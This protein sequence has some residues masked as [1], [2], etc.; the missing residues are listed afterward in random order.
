MEMLETVATF[1]RK[2]GTKVA[3]CPFDLT[4][5][6]S[7]RGIPDRV[8]SDIRTRGPAPSLRGHNNLGK[9]GIRSPGS[10]R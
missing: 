10:V 2:Y 5:E 1:T 7:F 9:D 6:E 4:A 8:K 3:C